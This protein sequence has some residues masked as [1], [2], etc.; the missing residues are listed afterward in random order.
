MHVDEDKIREFLH[1]FDEFYDPQILAEWV[2]CV[3]LISRNFCSFWARNA[4]FFELELLSIEILGQKRCNL[5]FE[6]E[7]LHIHF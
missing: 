1:Q 5:I 6:V 2:F 7:M 4:R 3:I